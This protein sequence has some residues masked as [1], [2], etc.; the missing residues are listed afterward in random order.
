MR[1]TGQILLFFSSFLLFAQNVRTSEAQGSVHGYVTDLGGL[2]APKARITATHEAG[3][4]V[5]VETGEDGGFTLSN[6]RAGNYTIQI[7]LQGFY[8][9]TKQVT[10]AAGEDL[11]L[12][13]ALKPSRTIAMPEVII[14]G[15]VIDQRGRTLQEVVVTAINAFDGDVKFRGITQ[16]DGQ[17]IIKGV[18]WGQYVIYASKPGFTA[19]T[20]TVSFSAKL[21]N[22][23]SEVNFKLSP[24]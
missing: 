23:K 4:K 18:E 8:I 22:Q 11:L 20:A 12:N 3:N 1:K 17:Y 2:P 15:K 19:Q 14:A 24:L 16:A 10:L 9:V 21:S 7:A 5:Q 6:L 13:A